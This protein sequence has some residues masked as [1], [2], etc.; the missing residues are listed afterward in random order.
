VNRLL[1]RLANEYARQ[2]L[3]PGSLPLDALQQQ[4]EQEIARSRRS[5]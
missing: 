1:Q 5:T 2:K 3:P 4:V